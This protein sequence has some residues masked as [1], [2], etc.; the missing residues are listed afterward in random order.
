VSEVEY[1]VSL[2]RGVDADA[3]NQEMIASS[4]AAA[5]PNRTVDI[6]DAREL[7][8]RLT[9]YSLT[10]AEAESLKADSRVVDVEIP[11]QDRD[12]VEIGHDSLQATFTKTTAD[13]GDYRDWG[14]IRHSYPGNV[15]G[16][17]STTSLNFPYAL[18]GT[19][20]DVVIQDS[21]IQV[22]HPEFEISS[23]V[24]P[25][26]YAAGPLVTDSTNGA[27]FDRS[28]NVHGLK[29]VVAGAVGGAT[30]VHSEFAKKVAR[31]VE[32]L[33]T[34]RRTTNTEK[35]K[36]LIENLRGGTGTWHA[37]TPTAQRI[38]YGGGASY[39]PNWL[40]D[41][42]IPSYSGYQGFLDSHT[43]HQYGLEARELKMFPSFDS[44]WATGPMFLAMKEAEDNSIFDPSGYAPNWKTDADTFPVAVKEYLYLLNFAMFEYTSLWDGGSLSPEWAN[45]AR[46]P[47]GVQANNPLGYG[48]FNTHIKDVIEKIDID[49]L[50]SIFPDGDTGNPFAAGA[51]GYVSNTSNSRVQLLDWGQYSGSV[52]QSAN[53]YRDYDGHGTHC[54]GTAVGLNYGW[55]KNARIY[56]QKL[57]GLEGSGDSG[58]GISITYA[59]DVITAWHN[60]KPIDPITGVKRPTI[61]NMSWGYSYPYTPS[62]VTA[63]SY[64]GVTYNSGNDSNLLN[65][66]NQ[67]SA[68][69]FYQYLTSG[70]YRVPLRVSSVDTNIQEMIDAG[71][72]V[73]V[74]A[75]NNRF[76]ADLSGGLDYNNTVST[77]TVRS[78]HRG[79][80]PTDDEAISV[81]SL[82]YAVGSLTEETKSLFSTTGPGV[83][84][85]AAGEYI[86]SATSTTNKFSAPS[87]YGNA[88]FKQTN[89]S[90]TSMASPQVC[91][92]GA[93]HLQ[94]N[95]H[96][97][98]AQLKDR[99]IKDT[100]A[101]L[102]DGGLTAYSTHTNIMGGNNRIMLSRYANAVPFSSNVAG[103][104]KR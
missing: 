45:S 54:A 63:F 19:G 84:I 53:H 103:L 55:G 74:A 42:G 40:L 10:A 38:G 15:Y 9:H 25:D 44:D 16:A 66:A 48:L 73:C 46:T 34:P 28:I 8:V 23:F 21:G 93:L 88:S 100:E 43:I 26:H 1:I 78:Y 62:N 52:T 7:S 85:Y 81:G 33:L 68:Y 5:I 3:F 30:T 47:A 94:A 51:S 76:K 36:K 11:P 56:S 91:G 102:Q 41:A 90:G 4:G 79:S 49:V 57:S 98:P 87:Y 2:K 83:D 77:P 101:R 69:G 89:I 64:R 37:G 86:I 72:H 22:D 82:G 59:F 39:S 24:A 6:A 14:K 70:G 80:S 97:T 58:T 29:I 75:G 61:V 20:V 17:G 18:D 104:K 35:Q 13:S 27:V 12:D 99:L 65:A 67:L 95:P 92:L 71:I 60:A 50:Q 96:W 31:T 32:L